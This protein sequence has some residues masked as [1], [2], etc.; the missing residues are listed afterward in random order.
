MLQLKTLEK[1]PDKERKAKYD[2]KSKL[3]YFIWL[4]DW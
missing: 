4:V 3:L 2:N 1:N